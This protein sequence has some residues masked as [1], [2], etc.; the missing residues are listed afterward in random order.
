MI[1]NKKN[2]INITIKDLST[3]LPITTISTK[4]EIIKIKKKYIK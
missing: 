2:I 4:K 1:Q 3:G